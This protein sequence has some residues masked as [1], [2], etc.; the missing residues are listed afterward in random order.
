MAISE[1]LGSGPGRYILGDCDLILCMS[2]DPVVWEWY[3]LLQFVGGGDGGDGDESEFL[4]EG[5]RKP[6]R[7]Y[8]DDHCL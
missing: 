3:L 4:F 7:I 6:S 1:M 8:I 5:K 2:W